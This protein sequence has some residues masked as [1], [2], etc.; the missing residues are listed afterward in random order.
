MKAKETTYKNIRFRSRLEARWAIFFDALGT[1]WE[2]E[3]EGFELSDGRGYLPDFSVF[4]GYAE[5]KPYG[6]DFDKARLFAKD[7][8]RI[9]EGSGGGTRAPEVYLL[10]GPPRHAFFKMLFPTAGGEVGEWD[11]VPFGD[12]AEKEKRLFVNATGEEKDFCWGWTFHKAVA[13]VAAARFE[14][15]VATLAEP[16]D[17]R[18]TI[19]PYYEQSWEDQGRYHEH[20]RWLSA[21]SR[22]MNHLHYKY[23]RR[24]LVEVDHHTA[25]H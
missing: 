1:G 2:Y 9:E 20:R 6:D 4:G 7:I 12:E 15:G 16:V 8:A 19:P 18:D 17:V 10:A 21:G 22:L 25:T 11:M 14:N 13:A 24:L 23:T 3:P 5:V